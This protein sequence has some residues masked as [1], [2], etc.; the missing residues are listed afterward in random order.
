MASLNILVIYMRSNSALQLLHTGSI[1]NS[2]LERGS[3]WKMK[4]WWSGVSLLNFSGQFI[5]DLAESS[6]LLIKAHFINVTLSL[7][8]K[9]FKIQ[10]RCYLLLIRVLTFKTILTYLLGYQN[11]T[12]STPWRVGIGSGLLIPC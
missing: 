6:T 7:L 10:C 2:K 12:T 5:H 8:Y 4:K 1:S 3:K 11:G 9:K